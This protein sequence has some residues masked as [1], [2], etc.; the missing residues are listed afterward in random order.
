MFVAVACDTVVPPGGGNDIVGGNGPLFKIEVS[1]LSDFTRATDT[2]F[3]Q[4]DVLS[5]YAFKGGVVTPEGGDL[6]DIVDDFSLWIDNGKFTRGESGFVGDKEYKWYDGEDVSQI[7]G[8]YPYSDAYSSADMIAQKI[9]FC[10][11]TDQSTHAGYTAS[12]LMTAYKSDVAPT[13]ESIQLA[14]NHCLSKIVIDVKNERGCN[15]VGVYLD[16]V[17]GNVSLAYPHISATGDYGT[18]KAGEISTPSEGF[19]NSFVLIIPPQTVAP[20]L[21][22]VTDTGEQI[23]FEN[24]ESAIEFGPGKVRHLVVTITPQSISAEFDAIVNDWS[25][26]PDVEFK[27]QPNSGNQGGNGDQGGDNE[28]GNDDGEGGGDDE[29]PFILTLCG[30]DGSRYAFELSDGAFKLSVNV[31][32]VSVGYQVA[33][34][35]VNNNPDFYGGKLYSTTLPVKLATN[36]QPFTFPLSGVYILTVDPVT[37]TL[38]VSPRIV[39]GNYYTIG[40]GTINEG[41]MAG[42][43]WNADVLSDNN[44]NYVFLTPFGELVEYFAT[45]DQTRFKP[46]ESVAA[47]TYVLVSV[48]ENKHKGVTYEAVNWSSSSGVNI[49]TGLMFNYQG[50]WSE[51]TLKSAN[52]TSPVPYNRAV[53]N[54]VFQTAP[55]YELVGLGTMTA[56]AESNNILTY[57]LPGH[58]MQEAKYNLVGVDY[59]GVTED[60][61]SLFTVYVERNLT[62]FGVIFLSHELTDEQLWEA[63]NSNLNNIYTYGYTQQGVADDKLTIDW[64]PAATGRYSVV[65]V[66]IDNNYIVSASYCNYSY[67]KQGDTGLPCEVTMVPTLDPLRP[68][69]QIVLNLTGKNITSANYSCFVNDGHYEN[70]SDAEL[71]ALAEQKGYNYITGYLSYMNNGGYTESFVNLLPSTEY[72]VVGWFANDF[73][74]TT[75]ARQTITTAAPAQWT[76]LGIGRFKDASH[77]FNQGESTRSAVEILQDSDGS[78]HYRIMKPYGGYWAKHSEGFYGSYDSI[79]EFAVYDVRSESGATSKHVCFDRHL[80]GATISG[81]PLYIEHPYNS[82]TAAL[83]YPMRDMAAVEVYVNSYCKQESELLFSIAPWYMMGDTNRGYNYTSNEYTITIVLPWEGSDQLSGEENPPVANMAAPAMAAPRATQL[84]PNEGGGSVK[85]SKFSLARGRRVGDVQLLPKAEWDVK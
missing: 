54:G 37:L 42:L 6:S 70:L 67:T 14:F 10:V 24:T 35:D 11:Q 57:L 80:T 46:S 1:G 83:H 68:E 45:G 29:Q 20:K 52:I 33:I 36:D 74:S 26:D 65:V 64:Q 16:G 61:T 72:I 9:N 7:I 32:D 71:V 69:D 30:S 44:G 59:A 53:A 12:D 49:Q 39:G 23:T 8:V 62:T 66:G 55:L 2:S 22:F 5:I 21:A 79:L 28:G 56:S 25:A 73:G 84:A 4:G 38:D 41:F 78:A 15:I 48:K 34:G 81:E 31:P 63:V 77:F 43:N 13:E 50:A 75:V 18:I 85:G 58:T 40:E 82:L 60:N 47:P 3:E 76:S 19:T 51:L 27:D 17:Q